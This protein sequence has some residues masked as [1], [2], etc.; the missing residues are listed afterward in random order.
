[1]VRRREALK[2]SYSVSRLG[3][4]DLIALVEAMMAASAGSDDM[5]SGGGSGSFVVRVNESAQQG[6]AAEPSRYVG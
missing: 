1:M 2:F 5:V 4:N 6:T 3:S